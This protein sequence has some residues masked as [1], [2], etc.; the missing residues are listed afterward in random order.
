MTFKINTLAVG[1]TERDETGTP[2]E[3]EQ[4]QVTQIGS[5]PI[6]VNWGT[7]DYARKNGGRPM[8]TRENAGT[9]AHV[10]VVKRTTSAEQAARDAVVK[11]ANC[12]HFDVESLQ[13]ASRNS[14]VT[15]TRVAVAK[16]LMQ[17]GRMPAEA[18][19]EARTAGICR[20]GVG[21]NDKGPGIF[22]P[23]ASCGGFRPHG[24]MKRALAW[25]RDRILRAAQG[26]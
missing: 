6:H 2:I 20:A 3:P 17:L 10:G 14:H 4:Q 1:H 11:C 18:E 16:G 21:A 26:K 5:M 9:L 25:A 15:D 19:V 7:A 23:Y 24:A 13:S 22:M 12:I 8:I